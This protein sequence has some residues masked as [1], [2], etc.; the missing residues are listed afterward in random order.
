[1]AYY[2]TQISTIG[3]G[4]A[5]DTNGKRLTFIGNYPCKA[6]DYVWTD[7]RFIFGHIVDYPQPVI[8][9]EEKSG[10]PV[11]TNQLRGYFDSKGTF[12]KYLISYGV[13]PDDTETDWESVLE[14]SFIV[15]NKIFK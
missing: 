3:V 4:Y 14:S 12:R 10:I 1:M 2:K 8:F 15:N 6:G 5:V 7:G 9:N 11:L 13:D